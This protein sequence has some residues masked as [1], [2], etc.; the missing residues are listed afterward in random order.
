VA[1]PVAV[2]HAGR[3]VRHAVEHRVYL[4]NHVLSVDDDRLATWRPERHV[5]D[6]AVFG[7]VDLLAAKHGVDALTQPDLLGEADEEAERL[8]GYAVLRVVE[9][10][11][12]TFDRQAFAATRVVGEE[13]A[14]VDVA[15]PRVMLAEGLPGR[16]VGER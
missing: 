13:L 7:D 8:V 4:R 1:R 10:Q 11:A 2:S 14:E 9:V 6:R 16:A 12:D 3:E 5:E 15:D